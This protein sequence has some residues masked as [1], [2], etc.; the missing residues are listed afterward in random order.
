MPP[1]RILEAVFY[2]LRTGIRRKALPKA[3]GAAGS[4]HQYFSERAEAG[5]FRRMRQEGLLASDELK[6]LGW[7]WQRVEGSMVKAP[8]TREAAGSNPPDRGK[9]GQNAVRRSNPPDYPWGSCPA[10][11]TGMTANCRKPRYSPS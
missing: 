3:Y 5:F 9:K 7:E 10:E 8:L 4:V 6:G 11:P 2:V 1:R